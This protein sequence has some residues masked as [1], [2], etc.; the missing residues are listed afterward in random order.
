MSSSHALRLLGCTLGQGYLFAAPMS[1]T[2]LTDHL[3]GNAALFPLTEPPDVPPAL[4]L[5]P[6]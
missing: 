5:L 4:I 2:Q 6:G 3:N 1:D